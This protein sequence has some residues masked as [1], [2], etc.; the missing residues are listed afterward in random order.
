MKDLRQ[1]L[2]DILESQGTEA[3]SAFVTTGI[4][5]GKFSSADILFM[6]Y[7]SEHTRLL[8]AILNSSID[9]NV[10]NGAGATA[11]YYAASVGFSDREK[12]QHRVCELLIQKGAQVNRT[13]KIVFKAPP[14]VVVGETA[15]MA[16]AGTNAVSIIKLLL[17]N[18]A[19]P[20]IKDKNGFDAYQHAVQQG[21]TEA[22]I[23]LKP[24]KC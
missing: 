13:H 12:R 7:W 15:L 4:T 18:G 3:V 20:S 2:T 14:R 17:A 9:V 16:A 11:L 21:K 19:D 22:A 6:A 5:D 10:T 8:E 24:A 1:R 23:V